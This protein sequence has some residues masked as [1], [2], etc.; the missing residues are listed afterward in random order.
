MEDRQVK[1]IKPSNLP[2][3]KEEIFDN[4]VNVDQVIKLLDLIDKDLERQRSLI[5]EMWINKYYSRVNNSILW[6]IF[7]GGPD[8]ILKEIKK[9][10]D[11]AS[12][13]VFGKKG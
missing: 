2:H 13:P 3:I 12:R 1:N 5:R 11:Y 9:D 8:K 10:F 4:L 6:R 7:V